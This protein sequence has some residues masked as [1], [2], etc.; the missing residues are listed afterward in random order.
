MLNITSGF[1]SSYYG[2]ISKLLAGYMSS[3]YI[4]AAS[5][6]IAML[7][8]AITLIII[9]GIFSYVFGWVERKFMARMQSRHGPTYVG[10]FGILQNLADLLKLISKENIIPSNSDRPFFG[11]SIPLMVAAF[12][13]MLFFIP[14]TQSYV[15]INTSIGLI[16]V[17]MVL[18]FVP[19][20]VFLAGW[21]SGN[22]F[23][24]IGAE[25]S[26]VMLISYEIPFILVIAAVAMLANSYSL[27]SIVS[28]QSHYWFA[29][30]MPIGL[31]VFFIIMLAEME[32]PPFDL[33]EADSELIAGWLTDVSA[34][35]YALVLFLDYVRLFVGSL[36]I[37]TLFFGGYMGPSI[38][39][40]LAWTLIKVVLISLFVVVI[41]STTVRM[42]I[43]R[44]LR[45]GWA[46]LTPLA[47]VNL[48]LTFVLFVH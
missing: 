27:N 47:V 1:V 14:L 6:I 18:S 19:L 2:S 15:G 16:A 44:V 23:A 43:D 4:S 26:V 45:L 30:L 41:R 35:Y 48:L 9:A 17:F 39:P 20:L 10:K 25:R 21:T 3:Q 11:L 38:L 32:R 33:R 22:K 29:L 40:P 24:S 31:L 12:I 37:A 42:R 7:I 46:Y 8:F 28:A 5:L 36:L 13:I 34:P